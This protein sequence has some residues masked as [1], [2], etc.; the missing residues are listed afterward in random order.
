MTR[1]EES[2]GPIATE[3]SIDRIS[4]GDVIQLSFSRE[5]WDH[6]LVV[7]RVAEPGSSGIYV[8]AHSYDADDRPLSSYQYRNIRYLHFVGVRK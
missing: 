4:P 8:T 3:T 5:A 1:S 2:I 6:T 7:V